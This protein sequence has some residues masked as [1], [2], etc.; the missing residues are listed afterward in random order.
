[1]TGIIAQVG[2]IKTTQ[3][4]LGITLIV[5]LFVLTTLK[6]LE[7]IPS[8]SAESDVANW[9]LQAKI[10]IMTLDRVFHTL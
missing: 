4:W 1:M 6:H 10:L 5:G 7:N 2:P 9:P 3:S 8:A